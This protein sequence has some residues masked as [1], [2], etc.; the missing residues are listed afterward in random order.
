ME[1]ILLASVKPTEVLCIRRENASE[2][3]EDRVGE[4]LLASVTVKRVRTKEGVI[5]LGRILLMG[6]I[7]LPWTVGRFRYR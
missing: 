3:G 7:P 2:R 1:G 4:T 6:R 5:E